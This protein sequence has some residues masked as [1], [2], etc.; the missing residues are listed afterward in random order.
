VA[1]RIESKAVFIPQ[2]V[3]AI[4]EVSA[5]NDSQEVG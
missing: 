5:A 4:A 2:R 1:G 3:G